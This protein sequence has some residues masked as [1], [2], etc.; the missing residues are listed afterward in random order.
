MM[1]LAV[2]T[3]SRASSLPQ[4]FGIAPGFWGRQ[5]ANVGASLLA[6]AVGQVTGCRL[7]GRYREQAHSYRGLVVGLG[8]V[9]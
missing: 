5:I 2:P 3:P 4:G 1:M 6:M 8:F 7:Y 9:A